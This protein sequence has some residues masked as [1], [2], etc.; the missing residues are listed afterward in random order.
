MRT[1]RAVKLKVSELVVGDT[2]LLSAGEKIPADGEM[3][4]GEIAVDQSPLN[5]E[6]REVRKHPDGKD[7]GTLNS[8][9]HVFC[10]SFIVSGSGSMTVTRVG[11]GTIYGKT[12]LETV[13]Q[14]RES[15]LRARLSHLAGTL[16][17]LGLCAA[18]FVAAADLFKQIFID[19][20]FELSRISA[21]FADTGGLLTCLIHALILAVTVVVVAVP[22]GLPMMI[23]VVLSSNMARM[24]KDGVL[25]R[26]PTGIE[27]AGSMNILFTDKTGTLTVGRLTLTNVIDSSAD[28]IS[29]QALPHYAFLRD[30]LAAAAFYG[31]ACTV[32]NGQ[33]TGGNATERAL[34]NASLLHTDKLP[35]LKVTQRVAFSSDR[36]Y[37]SVT[38]SDGTTYIKGAPEI[39]LAACTGAISRD[40]AR[41]PLQKLKID[42]A[43]ANAASKMLRVVAIAQT[44][45]QAEQGKLKNLD[46]ICL[47][48]MQDAL[49]PAAKS[50]VNELK[51][52][53]IQTVMLTGDG[54]GTAA[55]IANE[56]GITK[57]RE[58]VFDASAIRNMS[59]GEL[60]EILPQ[61]RV[62][63]R[64]LPSDKSRLIKAAQKRGLVV[65]MTG[66]GVNDAPALKIADVGFA[67]GSGSDVAKDAGDIVILND[68]ISSISKAVLYGRTIF[69][70]I[71][72]FIV[73][74]LTMNLCAVGVSVLGPLIGVEMPITVIQMLWVNM[75]MDTLAGL[76]F[77]FEPPLK[78]YMSHPPKERE[79]R[80]LTRDMLWR[81]CRMGIYTVALCTAFL[82]L[83]V[84][85]SI[86]SSGE[87]AFMCAFFTL[88]IFAA[89]FNAFTARTP[90]IMLTANL[91]KNRPFCMIIAFAAAVQIFL[92]FF[93]G[94]MFR[95]APLS[96]GEILYV[97]MLSFT[98]I[99]WE[100]MLRIIKRLQK[101]RKTP[102]VDK[103]AQRD[104]N[105]AANLQ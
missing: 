62:I 56:A 24:L 18:L 70:S 74:Q 89:L 65:G 8:A 47:C 25:V 21:F 4:S 103:P 3:L 37:S 64:S 93:G 51:S 104:Y 85:K 63:A 1:G 27:T 98:V 82:S 60:A 94:D 22:E 96:I 69:L 13:S 32:I 36:K 30:K 14:T 48:V 10:G 90:R 46:L 53:G 95:T 6:S 58:G 42:R 84:F 29:V 39:I 34:L 33:V 97:I 17:K 79:A 23:T 43:A 68:D 105:N 61:I 26:K 66:D 31:T 28:E 45:S 59:D 57:G 12:A 20:G 35:A 54:V 76:A 9:R 71:R 92:I 83:P 87:T 101:S 16:S 19:N 5:G 73:F 80:V 91:S 7:D 49:R 81:I 40:G 102:N 86:F 55:A 78:E 38:L 72:K 100:L 11:D 77:S 52:A 67:M 15:P 41:V 88:F 75:I 44:T 99:P 50:A 2:V